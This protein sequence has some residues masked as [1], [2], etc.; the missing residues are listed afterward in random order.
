[1]RASTTL[2]AAVLLAVATPAAAQ[3][4]NR[5]VSVES[6]V[7]APLSRLGA[8]GGTFALGATSWLEGAVDATAR[9]AFSAAPRTGG[10]ASAPSASGTAGVRL[11]LLPDPLRPQLG[12]ELGWARV[13][14][15]AGGEDRVAFAVAAGLEWFPARDL[16]ITTRAA[17]HGAGRAASLELTLSLGAYF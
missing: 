7:S 5:S 8:G 16:S 13:A 3:V 2:A 4:R 6:G 1:M 11:S 12:L 17:L 9:V 15:P 10:R 14:G